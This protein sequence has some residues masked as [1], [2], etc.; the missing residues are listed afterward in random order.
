MSRRTKT[1]IIAAVRAAT[2]RRPPVPTLHELP[3]QC[4]LKI[5]TVL[6]VTAG[7]QIA[8]SAPGLNWAKALSNA[9]ASAACDQ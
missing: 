7:H 4:R 6:I 3:Q 1:K 2:V 9:C 8:F 5:K